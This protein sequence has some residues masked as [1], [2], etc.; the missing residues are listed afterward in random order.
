MVS[1][2]PQVQAMQSMYPMQAMMITP[3]YSGLGT[4]PV[5][6]AQSG[7][8]TPAMVST[9][10]QVHA[11]QSMYPMQAMWMTPGYPGLGTY[12]VYPVY[13]PRPPPAMK[14]SGPPY[15]ITMVPMVFE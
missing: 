11:M 8:W 7:Q 6:P 12:P 5:Y 15:M 13:P 1:T 9:P 2:P 4:Y 10:P 3:G 14:T